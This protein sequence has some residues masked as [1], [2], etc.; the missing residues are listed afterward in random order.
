MNEE[1][2]SVKIAILEQRMNDFYN[3]INKLDSAIEKI[4]EVN[5]NI[6]KMLA[7]HEEKIG[8]NEKSETL[9]AKMNDELKANASSDRKDINERV[10]DLYKEVDDLKRYKW[11][12]VAF[13]I[14]AALVVAG[15]FQL[16]SGWDVNINQP[17]STPAAPLTNRN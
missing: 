9:L 2:N 12:S 10:D 11:M 3:V 7:V 8:Q 14:V 13:G 5:T 16:A 4:S 6:I 1:T 17:D 15:G